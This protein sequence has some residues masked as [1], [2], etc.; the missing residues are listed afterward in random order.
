[1]VGCFQS[2]I[3]SAENWQNADPR[4]DF[5]SA[6][7]VNLEQQGMTV[8]VPTMVVIT[9]ELTSKDQLYGAGAELRTIAESTADYLRLYVDLD[10]KIKKEKVELQQWHDAN[11]DLDLEM[12]R[13]LEWN[14]SARDDGWEDYV[15]HV[16]HSLQN[17]PSEEATRATI[18]PEVQILI[19][20]F[21]AHTQ[22][23]TRA[24]F[25][26]RKD[27]CQYDDQ[28][29][30]STSTLI[31]DVCKL[32]T[33]AKMQPDNYD[34]WYSYMK[35]WLDDFASIRIQWQREI[36]S[37]AISVGSSGQGDVG[38]A[39]SPAEPNPEL[40]GQGDAPDAISGASSGSRTKEEQEAWDRIKG[41]SVPVQTTVG[42]KMTPT[43]RFEQ[44][45]DA[46][47]KT[48]RRSFAT[49]GFSHTEQ[50]SQSSA[51]TSQEIRSFTGDAYK[52]GPS[53]NVAWVSK[54]ARKLE[55]YARRVVQYCILSST[56]ND[57]QLAPLQKANIQTILNKYVDILAELTWTPC[58]IS[59][60]FLRI[61]C[62]SEIDA[63]VLTDADAGS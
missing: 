12:Y 18:A 33:K 62:R 29:N 56:G 34:E 31:S 5:L 50:H 54:T 15:Y 32:M 60:E 11:P 45:L 57:E 44:W 4:R 61:A 23:L 59:I 7:W 43:H 51:G 25:G 8:F 47:V 26:F 21:W 20:K 19:P 39:I 27:L 49:V 36:P 38:D 16:Y 22:A 2:I 55:T 58:F 46:E 13:G 42:Q 30:Q 48:M 41:I 14:D 1:M 17:I 6:E 52:K 35:T 37:E 3:K 9:Q 40:S 24:W 53:P 10:E 63:T 28:K